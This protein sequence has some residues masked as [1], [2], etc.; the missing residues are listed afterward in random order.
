MANRI[1]D[2]LMIFYIA[3]MDLRRIND[4]NTPFLAKKFSEVP[5]AKINTI[6]ETDLVPTIFTGSYPHVHKMWQVK[7]NP[8]LDGLSRKTLSESIPDLVTTTLQCLI[9]L[10]TGSFN[11]AAIPHWRRRRMEIYKTRFMRRTLKNYLTFNGVDTFLSE[12]GEKDSMYSYNNRLDHISSLLPKFCLKNHRLEILETHSMDTLQHWYLDN[13]ER[14]NRFYRKIDS[15]IEE[16]HKKCEKKGFTLM[17]LSDHGQEP[18]RGSIDLFERLG[19]LN[20]SRYEYTFYIEAPKARF[21]F[22][23]DSA[24]ERITHMLSSVKHGTLLPYKDMHEHNVTFDDESYGEYYFIADPGYIFFPNDFYHPLGNIF[25]GLNDPQQRS[26]FSSPRY[27]GYHGY[28][29]HHESEKGFMLLLDDQYKTE[30]NEVDLID[31]AP[32]VLGLLGYDKPE[33]MKGQCMFN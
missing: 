9:H 18:V 7:L 2:R 32:T 15:L 31:F 25:M 5:W 19:K 17:V 13:P 12:V 27:R 20:I 16:F 1:V 10:Y 28:L 24:R 30:H 14:I 8:N 23:S 11:L 29:P 3:A 26:R 4:E 21:W 33:Y 22:H 6:P